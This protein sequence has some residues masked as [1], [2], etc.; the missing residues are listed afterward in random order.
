MA[1]AVRLSW[2]YAAALAGSV[3]RHI[4]D[5]QFDDAAQR[6]A[7]M[8]AISTFVATDVCAMVVRGKACT[9][10]SDLAHVIGFRFRALGRNVCFAQSLHDVHA[11]REHDIHLVIVLNARDDSAK[12]A[13]ACARR[14]RVSVLV[15]TRF[16]GEDVRREGW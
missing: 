15:T 11:L 13:A 12:R 3:E 8:R 10:K 16:D 2:A 7:V 14:W 5:A 1:E 9:G 6:A 4:L